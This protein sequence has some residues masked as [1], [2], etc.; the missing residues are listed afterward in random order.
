M[1]SAVKD[2]N[3]GIEVL[4]PLIVYGRDGSETEEIRKIYH[5]DGI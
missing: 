2:G 4:P 5:R 3:E 1:I